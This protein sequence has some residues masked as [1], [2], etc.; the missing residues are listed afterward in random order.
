MVSELI[1][2]A[3]SAV[4][5]LGALQVGLGGPRSPSFNSGVAQGT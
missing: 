5:I 3:T 4:M 2:A 1:K